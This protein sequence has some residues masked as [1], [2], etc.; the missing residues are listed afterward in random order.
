VRTVLFA[1]HA[2]CSP[3]D[4]RKKRLQLGA[5]VAPRLAALEK[6]AADSAS[7]A[8]AQRKSH[9]SQATLKKVRPGL[10][11]TIGYG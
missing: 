9:F 8:G 11:S 7:G 5:S 2:G 10:F 3:L 6:R 4:Y 1:E